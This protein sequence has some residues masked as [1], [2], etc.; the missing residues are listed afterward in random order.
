MPKSRS[1]AAMLAAEKKE[2]SMR[3]GF[4]PATTNVDFSCLLHDEVLSLLH[5]EGFEM[6]EIWWLF[7]CSHKCGLFHVCFMMKFCLY[8]IMKDLT[9][10][11]QYILKLSHSVGINCQAEHDN[12]DNKNIFT[13]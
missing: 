7:S 11:L 1:T 5:H 9:D 6:V 10:S 13:C 4:S 12:F 8:F 2:E 3:Y